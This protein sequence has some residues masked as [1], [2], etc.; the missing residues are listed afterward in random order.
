MTLARSQFE[1]RDRSVEVLVPEINVLK[2]QLWI[3]QERNFTCFGS[4]GPLLSISDDFGKF[5]IISFVF[6][7]RY[8]KGNLLLVR[9]WSRASSSSG[10]GL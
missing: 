4:S 2:D 8:I 3:Q 1:V 6:I 9:T 10:L 7:R 5:L